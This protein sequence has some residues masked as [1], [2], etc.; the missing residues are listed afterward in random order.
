MEMKEKIRAFN[1]SDGIKPYLERVMQRDCIPYRFKE[2]NVIETPLSGNAF[3]IVIE[4][5]LCEKQRGDIRDIPVYSYRTITNPKKFK[6]LR[7]INRF[8]FHHSGWQILGQR[9]CTAHYPTK[10]QN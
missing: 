1:V 6:R 8:W 3:H 9:Q 2:N 5:A 7:E 10:Q 4:D